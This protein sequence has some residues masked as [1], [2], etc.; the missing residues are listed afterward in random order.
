M[1]Y[2]RYK[3]FLNEET[4]EKILPK[5]VDGVCFLDAD[6]SELVGYLNDQADIDL[7]TQWS[8]VELTESEF[9]DLVLS[10]NEKVKLVNGLITFPRSI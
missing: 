7:L 4:N 8:V 9:L 6:E 10:R 2:A 1:R 5:E 3:F